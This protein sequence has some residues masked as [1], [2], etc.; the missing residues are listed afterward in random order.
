MKKSVGVRLIEWLSRLVKLLRRTTGSG[1]VSV[2][3]LLL[4]SRAKREEAERA[5][6]LAEGTFD[7]VMAEQLRKVAQDLD[8]EASELEKRASRI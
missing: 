8:T 3:E 6:L 1:R 5:R 2:E 7:A 4:S